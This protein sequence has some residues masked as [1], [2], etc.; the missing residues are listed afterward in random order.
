MISFERPDSR[1]EHGPGEIRMRAKRIADALG[2]ER[3]SAK[4]ARHVDLLAQ[5]LRLAVEH[6]KEAGREQ[7]LGTR[8]IAFGLEQDGQ[9]VLRDG[10][11]ANG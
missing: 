4:A 1:G 3:L 8:Q 11:V 10:V 5:H 9:A 6:L 7:L 2:D